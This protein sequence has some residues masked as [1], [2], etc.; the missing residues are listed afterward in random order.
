MPIDRDF[1][2][3]VE[4]RFAQEQPLR[5]GDWW[6]ATPYNESWAQ[7]A[8][9]GPSPYAGGC[10]LVREDGLAV[11]ISSNPGIHGR[12][13]TAVVI[14]EIGASA[15]AEEIQREIERRTQVNLSRE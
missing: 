13:E 6:N 15:T 11:S 7:V 4:D 5:E 12:Y 14:D 8:P 1:C 9:V 2:R 3:S 10:Y